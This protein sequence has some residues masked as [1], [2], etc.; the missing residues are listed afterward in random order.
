MC[1]AAASQVGASS[2]SPSTNCT[3]VDVG[4]NV[5]QPIEPD[6]PGEP[7]R[8]RD[9]A[10]E[11]TTLHR[12]GRL[13]RS[14]VT[15]SHVDDGLADRI[16]TPESIAYVSYDATMPTVDAHAETET[17]PRRGSPSFRIGD[18]DDTNVLDVRVGC[19]GRRQPRGRL[20]IGVTVARC[21]FRRVRRTTWAGTPTT[22]APSGTSESTTA[23][24]PMSAPSPTCTRP[25]IFAPAPTRHAVTEDRRVREVVHASNPERHALTNDAVV[26]DDRSLRARRCRADARRRPG[27]PLFAE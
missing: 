27:G 16:Q 7:S 18:H 23:F 15:P 17:R 6:V 2:Q 25:R 10:A 1:E 20:L 4:R 11:L 9:L 24:A 12:L 22:S 21:S 13:E 19:L 8:E 26:A 3:N 14:S 5:R